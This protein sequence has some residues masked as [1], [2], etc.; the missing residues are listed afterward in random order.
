MTKQVVTE[1]VVTEQ[2][3]TEQVVTEQVVTEQVVTEQVVNLFPR[4]VSDVPCSQITLRILRGSLGV[5]MARNK[6]CVEKS[7]FDETS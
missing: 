2:V 4:T 7:Y 1:Q 6:K 5:H 3:V